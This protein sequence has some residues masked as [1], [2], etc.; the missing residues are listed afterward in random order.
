MCHFFDLFLQRIE[1]SDLAQRYIGLGDFTLCMF[2][3]SGLAGLN[4]F[5][6]RMI[7]AADTGYFRV[8]FTNPTIAAIT[9]CL[10]HAI[11]AIQQSFWY[12]SSP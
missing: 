10:Q 2:H 6:A 8:G 12:R 5:T 1:F 11:K 3:I 7:P 9:I 4:E